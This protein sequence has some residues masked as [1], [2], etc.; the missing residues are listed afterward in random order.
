MGVLDFVYCFSFDMFEPTI[1][2]SIFRPECS[3]TLPQFSI[4]HYIFAFVYTVHVCVLFFVVF[5][6]FVLSCCL[7]VCLFA[8]LLVCLFVCLFVSV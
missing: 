6:C 1:C 4:A 3:T 5:C 8:C 7:H 2:I